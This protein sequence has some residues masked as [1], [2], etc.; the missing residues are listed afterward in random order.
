MT[1]LT[2]LLL[3]KLIPEKYLITK[4]IC[5]TIDKACDTL[6]YL[7]TDITIWLIVVC[8]MLIALGVC[9]VLGMRHRYGG[10]R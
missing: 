4:Q 2:T 9:Y 6:V 7:R 10:K 8:L 3:T 1:K 5:K